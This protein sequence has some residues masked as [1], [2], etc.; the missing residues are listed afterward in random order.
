MKIDQPIFYAVDDI[1][2]QLTLPIIVISSDSF[3]GSNPSFLHKIFLGVAGT[4]S[5]YYSRVF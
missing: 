3:K 1:G 5:I 2:S 4:T